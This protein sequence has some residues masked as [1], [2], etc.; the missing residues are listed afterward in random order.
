MC[1]CPRV[2]V[3]GRNYSAVSDGKSELQSVDPPTLTS[4]DKNRFSFD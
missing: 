4:S 3:D 1:S 2:K